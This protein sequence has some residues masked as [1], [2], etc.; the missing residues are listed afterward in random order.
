MADSQFELFRR[1]AEPAAEAARPRSRS[2]HDER[3]AGLPDES[4]R[5]RIITDLEANLLVEAGAGAG[6][7]TE[8]VYRMT[9][10]V[11]AGTA[12]DRIAAVTFTR[13]AAAELRERFQTRLEDELRRARGVDDTGTIDIIDRALREIDRAF[14]G[15]IHSFCARLLRDRPLEAGIDPDF[16][17]TFAVEQDRLRQE[18]FAGHVE[19]LAASGDPSLARLGHIGLRPD[20]L[21]RL[22][23]ELTEHGD[24]EFPADDV[25]RP[26][27]AAARAE[28]SALIDEALQLMPAD[29]PENGW[30]NLQATVRRLRFYRDVVGWTDDTRFL[31]VLAENLAVMPRAT[32]KCW[33][34]SPGISLVVR[35]LVHRFEEFTGPD[36]TGGHVLRQWWAHRYPIVIRFARNAARLFEEERVR[37]GTVT[38]QDLLSSTR[39][40]LRRSPSARADLGER[41]RHI[42]VDE[43]QD[44]DPM[45]AEVLFL[46]ASPPSASDEAEPEWRNAVPRPGALF[47]VG[48]PKQSI[49]RFRRADITIYNHV[50]QRFDEIGGIVRLTANF[51]SGPPIERLVDAM[52]GERFPAQATE[53]QAAFAP[54][55]VQRGYED[56]Q[57]VCWYDVPRPGRRPKD[58]ELNAIDARRVASWI[59]ERIAEGESPGSFL[60][61]TRK[62]RF[63]T[64]YARE[65]EARNLPVQVTGGGVGIEEELAELRALLAALADPADPSLTVAV[66]VGLFFGLDYEKLAEHVLERRGR[67]DFTEAPAERETDVDRALGR[68]HDFW[69]LARHEPADV[70]VTSMVYDLGLLPYAAAGELGESRA[71]ALLFVLEAVR[72]ACLRG[73]ASIAGSITAIDA[74][75]EADEAEAPLE[76]GRTDV[77]RVMNLHQAKGLEAEIVVLAAPFGEYDHVPTLHVTRQVSGT[78]EGWIVVAERR[79]RIN[80]TVLARP[81]DWPEH[82]AIERSFRDAEEDRLLYVA[83]TRARSTLVIGRYEV[84]KDSP[85]GAFHPWLLAGF[86]A[87]DLTENP[88]PPRSRLELSSAEVLE[89]I[90]RVNEL[91]D[92]L[93]RPRWVAEAVRTRVKDRTAPLTPAADAEAQADTASPPISAGLSASPAGAVSPAA[94]A[95]PA[96]EEDGMIWGKLVHEALEEAA[97]GTDAEALRAFCRTRL[98]TAEDPHVD[99]DGEPIDLDRLL[100]V[101]ASVSA[102]SIW[103]RTLRSELVLV[104]APFSLTVPAEV[105]ASLDGVRPIESVA[106]QVIDGVIDLAFRENG[107]WIIVDYKSDRAGSGVDAA[108][109]EQYEGQVALYADCWR[110]LTGEPVHERVIL[111]TSDGSVH[112]W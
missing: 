3:I 103:Q 38:F 8:M 9:A 46:L 62:K 66:L 33:S 42:L 28:L 24:V 35:E 67:L 48:D 44:T 14:I 41:Y 37:T 100:E 87:I 39:K 36:G 4:E 111:F 5:R 83:A 65:I 89:K 79:F 27:P 12:V 55:Q 77:I 56:G 106:T 95:D 31:H 59:E 51:R 40:L 69:K 54:L 85:W 76:P 11:E 10:L 96:A 25:A 15:T 98:L 91:R 68:L 6:K 57:D 82:E 104:E 21:R 50:K 94:S 32:F 93:A 102:S 45:Q 29:E 110:R 90:E 107:G 80:D 16:R 61:L 64:A 47:V 112:A 81:L 63:L 43:F 2:F 84:E 78:A 22:F 18:F 74:A 109:L 99:A 105:Y 7:T 88:P 19:R 86:Q 72:N 49:Y 13:K 75:L 101:T 52:F 30:D 71:G 97:R 23:D 20:Q 92:S 53:R 73:D 70:V 17:E 34:D 26:D 60:I 1:L 58:T 108:V